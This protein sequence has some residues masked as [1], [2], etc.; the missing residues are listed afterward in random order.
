MIMLTIKNFS[1]SY[2]QEKILSFPELKIPKGIHWVK[3][4]NGSG[5]TTFFK[6]LSGLLPYHGEISF[7]DGISLNN[8]PVHFRKLIN[9]GEAEPLYPGFLTAKDIIRFVGKTKGS[10]VSHQ[11]KITEHFEI[12]AFEEKSCQ[13]YS[14]GMLK[15]LS[16]ALAFLGTPRCIILDE[17][18][19]TLD[20]HAR[21]RLFDMINDSIRKDG[22]SFLISSHQ[23][24]E[25]ISIGP[26]NTY[27]IQ[28]KTIT[29]A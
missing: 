25:N 28:D 11:K 22:T 24:I 4:E 21:C 2:Y 7:D 13:T 1:K 6:A 19:I 23:V 3:G 16:L 10:S 20:E 12:P 5:K 18:L 15:K 8:N 9:Y 29:L 27:T 26:I 14:S 17:P